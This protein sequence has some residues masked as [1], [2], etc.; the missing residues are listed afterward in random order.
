MKKILTSTIISLFLLSS[1]YA[2]ESRD[3]LLETYGDQWAQYAEAIDNFIEGHKEDTKKLSNIQ[4]KTS[5][6]LS[7]YKFKNTAKSKKI[8]AVIEFL[9]EALNQAL[10][11]IEVKTWDTISVHYEGLLENWEK[12][13]S[14]YDRDM[15]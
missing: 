2:W 8:K 14:S 12:F 7:T 11:T 5:K 3:Y 9:S 15:W 13:D 1:A 4:E 10:G 6:I